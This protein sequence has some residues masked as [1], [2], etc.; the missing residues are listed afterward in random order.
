MEPKDSLLCSQQPLPL[1]PILS[2]MNPVHIFTPYFF[3]IHSNIILPSTSRF[4]S[5][6]YR[7]IKR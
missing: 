4:S 1:V 7:P 3:K 6:Y 5:A 2:Q